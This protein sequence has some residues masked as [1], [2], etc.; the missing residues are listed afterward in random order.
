MSVN[1]SEFSLNYHKAVVETTFNALLAK[2]GYK[3]TGT[4]GYGSY[5]KVKFVLILYYLMIWLID[6]I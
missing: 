3:L 5:A 1:L 2:K 4:I 6:L